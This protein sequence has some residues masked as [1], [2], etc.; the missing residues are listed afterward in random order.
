MCGFKDLLIGEFLTFWNYFLPFTP[1]AKNTCFLKLFPSQQ[2]IF[3]VVKMHCENKGIKASVHRNSV[4]HLK[5]SLL[6]EGLCEGICELGDRN[7]NCIFSCQQSLI[8]QPFLLRS[9]CPS[10][11]WPG[12]S[13]VW[14]GVGFIFI[15]HVLKSKDETS[16]IMM[17]LLYSPAQAQ[18]WSIFTS[19][20][21]ARREEEALRNSCQPAPCPAPSWRTMLCDQGCAPHFPP[22]QFPLMCTHDRH[23]SVGR[24]EW[25]G[26]SCSIRTAVAELVT[27]FEQL[28]II[29]TLGRLLLELLFIII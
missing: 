15:L 27:L 25:W 10:I 16:S 22:F 18:S 26:F 5:C 7:D 12:L 21:G 8:L 2:N 4:L 20:G 17:A 9:V 19:S 24:V 1:F 28:A 11:K 29:M 23:T 13:L 6:T 14:E 3:C